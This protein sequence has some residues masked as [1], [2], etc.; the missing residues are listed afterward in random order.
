M[1]LK[2]NMNRRI[3]PSM[4]PIKPRKNLITETLLKNNYDIKRFHTITIFLIFII[5]GSH[6]MKQNFIV[7]NKIVKIVLNSQF[8]SFFWSKI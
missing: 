1:I 2:L 4:R 5:V 3:R 6:R 8:L 7:Q